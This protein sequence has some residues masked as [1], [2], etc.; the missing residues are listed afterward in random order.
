M[1]LLSGQLDKHLCCYLQQYMYLFLPNPPRGGFSR[2]L[3]GSFFNIPEKKGS[4][5]QLLLVVRSNDGIRGSGRWSDQLI[6]AYPMTRPLRRNNNSSKRTYEQTTTA[7]K[8]QSSCIIIF[9][10]IIFSS[11]LYVEM[12]Y[13]S[14]SAS[15]RVCSCVIYYS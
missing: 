13:S 6:E 12:Y 15:S 1:M 14:T 3:I 9:L 2:L 8:G 4:R 10:F 11:F 5:M 7:S